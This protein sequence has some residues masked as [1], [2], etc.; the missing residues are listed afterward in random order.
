MLKG[1]LASIAALKE[2]GTNTP[3]CFIVLTARRL[4]I[5]AG[6]GTADARRQAIPASCFTILAG[7]RCAISNELASYARQRWQW[8]DTR[9]SRFIDAMRSLTKRCTGK[10]TALL[11]VWMVDQK[12]QVQAERRGELQSFKRR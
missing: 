7:R 11:D 9:P 8:S 10:G 12:A 6:F 1:Q 3:M 2:Q 5:S 4:R